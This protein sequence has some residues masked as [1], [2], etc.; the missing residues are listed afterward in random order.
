V[1]LLVLVKKSNSSDA[2]VHEK[3]CLFDQSFFLTFAEDSFHM[4][5]QTAS[6][7]I[8]PEHSHLYQ[9]KI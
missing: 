2:K 5:G 4:A 6:P 9:E 3:P 1:Y 7:Q 8:H